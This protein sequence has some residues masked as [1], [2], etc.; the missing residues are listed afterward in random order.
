MIYNA[1]LIALKFVM[2]GIESENPI[3]QMKLQKMLFIAQGIHLVLND[4]KPLFEEPI[5]A[6]KYGPVVPQIYKQYKFYGSQPI[7][8]TELLTMFNGELPKID[9]I[10]PAATKAIDLTWK[11][12]KDI[13]ASKLSSW[14]HNPNSPWS[15]IFEQSTNDLVIP[16]ELIASYFDQFVIKQPE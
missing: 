15:K 9:D 12:T 16:N 6:W 13:S 11:L 1:S 10:N 3:T 14:T 7:L 4:R 5:Q 2:L 8:D